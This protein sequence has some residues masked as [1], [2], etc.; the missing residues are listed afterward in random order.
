[1]SRYS[2]LS[3]I[4]Y[5]KLEAL[6]RSFIKDSTPEPN[7]SGRRALGQIADILNKNL[8]GDLSTKKPIFNVTTIVF[9]PKK[10]A[11]T[12]KEFDLNKFYGELDDIINYKT[13][14]DFSAIFGQLKNIKKYID[15]YLK[16]NK[17]TLKALKEEHQQQAT[18]ENAQKE[19]SQQIDKLTNILTDLT[20]SV[21]QLK[22]TVEIQAKDLHEAKKEIIKGQEERDQILQV[23][24]PIAK[25]F[26]GQLPSPQK[27]QV[28]KYLPEPPVEDNASNIS[29]KVQ[30]VEEIKEI[31]DIN[32][33]I[34]DNINTLFANTEKHTEITT[35]R[36]NF[37]KYAQG[38]Y[39]EDG[40]EFTPDIFIERYSLQI[41][42]SDKA[43]QSTDY[44]TKACAALLFHCLFLTKY[45]FTVKE[46]L[47]EVITIIEKLNALIP[48]ENLK[49]NVA[50]VIKEEFNRTNEKIQ[51]TLRGEALS[52]YEI[53][54][55]IE[56]CSKPEYSI[57][58]PQADVY[59]KFYEN[60]KGNKKLGLEELIQAWHQDYI[61][62]K[63]TFLETNAADDRKI[64]MKA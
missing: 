14:F 42:L 40:K 33:R 45:Q 27:Q 23:F 44:E 10:D 52:G 19:N 34:S 18:V 1:M 13:L 21:T 35:A 58:L 61:K 28:R 5:E 64:E 2:E 7:T 30:E 31:S 25:Q 62:N 59:Q 36:N 38:Y 3:T 32:N 57:F 9:N 47:N 56:L 39:S 54:K 11:Q 55:M 24:I 60:L 29:V 48:T 16:E 20:A 4:I 41:F 26:Y 37:R 43:K 63:Q 50:K 46:T 17:T 12:Q 15:K 6:Y 53:K 8:D 49:I 51:V 22:E